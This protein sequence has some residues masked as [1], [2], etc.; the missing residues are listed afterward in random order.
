MPRA[1]CVPP[2]RCRRR[3]SRRSTNR[4]TRSGGRT[5]RPGT[6]RRR[7]LSVGRALELDGVAFGVA[8]IDRDAVAFRAVAASD[9]ADLDAVL[10][11]VGDD[12]F[13]IEGLD[14]QAK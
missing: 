11:Q 10:L 7:R 6:S 5:G 4:A 8:E 3:G 13:L 1:T 9:R 2:P 14:A 12:R